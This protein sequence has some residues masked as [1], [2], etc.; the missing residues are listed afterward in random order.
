MT[1]KSIEI[2]SKWAE[3]RFTGRDFAN[4][5]SMLSD[6]ESEIAERFME[7]PLDAEGEPC[8]VGDTLDYEGVECEVVAVDGDCVWFDD[9]ENDVKLTPEDARDCR[10]RHNLTV[11]DV[12]LDFAEHIDAFDGNYVEV[13]ADR[14]REAVRAE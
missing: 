8:H 9:D 14:L 2:L 1:L 6:V 13:Y 3:R 7:L 10:H 5:D 4:V 12:L 11:E